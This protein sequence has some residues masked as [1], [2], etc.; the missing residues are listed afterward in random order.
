MVRIIDTGH[1][2]WNI[3]RQLFVTTGA[4]NIF[5]EL[6]NG[7]TICTVLLDFNNLLRSIFVRFADYS[8]KILRFEKVKVDTIFITLRLIHWIFCALLEFIWHDLIRILT[9]FSRWWLLIL[10]PWQRKRWWQRTCGL[11][12]SLLSL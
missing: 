2:L 4:V 3:I 12:C 10:L 9:F 7:I 1:H 5:R 8:T 11:Y 6:N